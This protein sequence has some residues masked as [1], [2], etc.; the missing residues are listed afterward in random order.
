MKIIVILAFLFSNEKAMP[1]DTV[2][3]LKTFN[4]VK[5]CKAFAAKLDMPPEEKKRLACLQFIN[6]QEDYTEI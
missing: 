4:T 1:Y 3:F 2:G 5:E 6:S